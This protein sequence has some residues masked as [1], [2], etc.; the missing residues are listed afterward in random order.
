MNEDEKIFDLR[1]EW[2]T[3]N[4]SKYSGLR[5]SWEDPIYLKKECFGHGDYREI[6]VANMDYVKWLEQKLISGKEP[7]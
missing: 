4:T 7:T 1:K 6:E 3:E 2:I 5:S